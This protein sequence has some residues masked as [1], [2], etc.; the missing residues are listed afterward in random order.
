MVFE[1]FFIFLI[2]FNFIFFPIFEYFLKSF[3]E[4]LT[5]FI[6]PVGIK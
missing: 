5:V 6:L 3:I 2:E 4:L 1:T